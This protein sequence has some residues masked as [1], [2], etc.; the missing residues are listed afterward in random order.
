M[1]FFKD[2]PVGTDFCFGKTTKVRYAYGTGN[3]RET[4]EEPMIWKKTAL[5]GL[6]VC[7]K[8][9]G[10]ASFDYPHTATGTNNYMRNHGHRM[11]FLSSLHK[12]LNCADDSWKAHEEGDGSP[13]SES[14]GS[15]FMS[16]FTDE[17]IKLI[18]PHK[19]KIDVPVGYTK[20]H[21]TIMEKDVMIGLPS[22]EQLG[23]RWSDNQGTFGVTFERIDTWV[24][25]A[26]TMNKRILGGY[27]RRIP[28][29]NTSYVMPV[30]KIKEDSPIDMDEF[31]RYVIRI[32]ETEF[33]GDIFAF[34][35]FEEEAA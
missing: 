25:D 29:D 15:G 7:V 35:G 16:R 9:G 34:L 31:G 3:N 24:T 17:E 33:E 26:D 14:N 18:E 19:M 10:F 1:V 6:S 20:A 5:N 32:P 30:I 27:S 2:L 11:Y 28:S 8:E 12:Y 13:Y 21:G 4:Y 22:A 23:G